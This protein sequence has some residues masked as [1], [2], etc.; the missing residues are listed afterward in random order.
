MSKPFI[1]NA[2][3]VA[4]A[5]EITH[6]Q[7]EILEIQA[8]TALPVTGGC[9]SSLVEEYNY[10]N[11][12]S[13]KSALSQVSGSEHHDKFN[14]VTKVAIEDLN[15]MDIVTADKVVGVLVSEQSVKSGK[16]I[17]IWPMGCFFENLRI[18][19]ETVEF[20]MRKNLQRCTAFSRILE[21]CKKDAS[22]RF[23]PGDVE[24]HQPMTDKIHGF[25]REVAEIADV[26]QNKLEEIRDQVLGIADERSRAEEKMYFYDGEGKPFCFDESEVKEIEKQLAEVS[27][28]QTGT[29][30]S[31]Y[32]KSLDIHLDTS[33]FKPATALVPSIIA[34]HG[35][36]GG[37]PIDGFGTVYLGEYDISPGA[38]RLTM[39]RI[40]L[41]SP[42]HGTVVLGGLGG[43]G[44]IPD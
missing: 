37:I 33:L 34:S 21:Q 18:A 12:I 41:G 43:N 32:T 13:F 2:H 27:P 28:D 23:T 39:M 3:A 5:G 30:P 19:G 35:P 25:F 15:V 11:L 22:G 38:R 10:K 40:E 1:Y 6:P 24:T 36:K 7:H 31:R 44:H 26:A 20:E 14:S 9:G 29:A 4:F 42:I 8:A 16:E 17:A